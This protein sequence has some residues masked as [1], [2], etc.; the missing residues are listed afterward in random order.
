[1]SNKASRNQ[2]N[3][4][5]AAIEH[6]VAES[7][8]RSEARRAHTPNAKAR[9]AGYLALGAA[10]GTLGL[11]GLRSAN[12]GNSGSAAPEGASGNIPEA[13]R[14]YLK[15]LPTQRTEIPV[16]GGIDDAAYAVDPETF[17]ESAHIRAGVEEVISDELRPPGIGDANFVIP[18]HAKVDVPVVPP[19]DSVPPNAR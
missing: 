18:A 14:D 11:L 9:V 19:L 15:S 12:G 2:S 7:R 6:M 10:V 5:P 8:A 4:S 1:M 17:D 3:L 16:G 13:T